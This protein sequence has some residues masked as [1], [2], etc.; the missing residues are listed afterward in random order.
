MGVGAVPF[1]YYRNR[2]YNPAT[3]RFISED[4]VGWASGQTNAYAYVN[5]NPVSMSDP[6]GFWSISGSMYGGFGFQFTVY[7]DGS[8]PTASSIT[9]V[10]IRGGR[11]AG[12][13]L[14]FD[15]NGAVPS[16]SSDGSSVTI[17]GFAEAGASLGPFNTS[18]GVSNGVEFNQ[19]GSSG[20][21]GF[22]G[23]PYRGAGGGIAIGFPSAGF[24][25]AACAAVGIE[26]T[27]TRGK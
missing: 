14:S 8:V 27:Y 24:G 11:G 4:P 18:I 7:G 6:F 23:R 21:P 17:G 10:G 12:I 26:V 16:K 3:A 2:Y 25:G 15:P 9:G 19:S 22:G 1:V 5:G 13:G 20:L